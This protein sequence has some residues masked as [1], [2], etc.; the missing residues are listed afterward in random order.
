VSATD[1]EFQVPSER[2]RGLLKTALLA[3]AAFFFLFGIWGGSLYPWDE[4]FYGEAARE[5]AE[6]GLGWLTLHYNYQPFFEKPPLLIWLTA[7]TYKVFGVNELAVRFWS[8]LA[9]FGCIAVL[10][11]LA[12]ELFASENIAFYSALALIGFPQFTRQARYGMMDAP[13]TFCI[14]L[15]MLLLWK[16]LRREKLLFFIGPVLALAFMFK[17]FAS[18]QLLFIIVLFSFFSGKQRLLGNKYLLAG[19]LTGLL[20]VI[21][22]HAHQYTTHGPPFLDQYFFHHIVDRAIETFPDR[23]PRGVFYY[24]GVL[25]NNVPLGVI[26]LLSLPYLAASALRERD[27]ER[28]HALVLILAGVVVTV[29]LFSLVTSKLPWY[30]LPVYPFLALVITA[31]FHRMLGRLPDK[32]RSLAGACLIVLFLI[33]V[34]RFVTSERHRTMD[35]Y[36]HLKEISLQAKDLVKK[37]E[38]LHVQ[39]I[40]ETP[41]I[42]FYSQR[43]VSALQEDNSDVNRNALIAVA[44]N[45]E[46]ALAALRQTAGRVE[47][48][49]ENKRY[50]L[51]RLAGRHSSEP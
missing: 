51:V 28:K 33:P 44:P 40:G 16:G 22:W 42:V 27:Q 10:F 24:F 9:G 46:D 19:M 18:F 36:P 41:V 48:M 25:A 11:Y 45:R 30:I 43:R 17:S 32:R 23:S 50:A 29:G 39:G 4:A 26:G 35:Y 37:T 15:G 49:R 21:P 12:R 47:V 6:E 8:A 31:S 3:F 14:L 38:T 2:H 5:I 34:I 7:L 1:H 20:L 13:L